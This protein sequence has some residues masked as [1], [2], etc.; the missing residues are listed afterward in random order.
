MT[1]F[2]PMQAKKDQ[3]SDSEEYM[4]RPHQGNSLGHDHSDRQ[5]YRENIGRPSNYPQVRWDC[6][7]CRRGAE[8]HHLSGCHHTCGCW[9]SSGWPIFCIPTLIRSTWSR[10]PGRFTGCSSAKN[11]RPERRKL[12]CGRNEL[13]RLNPVCRGEF[14]RDADFLP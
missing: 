5:P 4:H 2:C 10:R 9:A 8:S 11:F 14:S 13:H 3:S 7:A 12:S 6:P 1:E